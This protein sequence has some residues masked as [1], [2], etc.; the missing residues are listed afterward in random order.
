MTNTVMVIEDEEAIATL[1]S[2]NLEKEGYKVIVVNNG[3]NA[4]NEVDKHNSISHYYLLLFFLCFLHN[5][6]YQK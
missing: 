5:Y 3:A 1:L 6:H 2:Y 4:V